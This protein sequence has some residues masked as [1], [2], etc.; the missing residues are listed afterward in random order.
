MTKMNNEANGARDTPSAPKKR[1]ETAIVLRS[2]SERITDAKEGMRT[3]R[4]FLLADREHD[5]RGRDEE[6]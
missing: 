6:D 1:D 3:L 4:A 2:I 5:N